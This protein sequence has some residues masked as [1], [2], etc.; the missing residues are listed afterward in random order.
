MTAGVS[1]VLDKSATIRRLEKEKHEAELKIQEMERMCA[2]LK[3]AQGLQHAKK[4]I[5][6]KGA[7]SKARGK[8]KGKKKDIELNDSSEE[9][10]EEE[11]NGKTDKDDDE[12]STYSFDKYAGKEGLKRLVEDAKEDLEEEP[13]K[14]L[15]QQDTN[16]SVVKPQ[17]K[18]SLCFF[19]DNST[20]KQTLIFA[21]KI[22]C[23]ND[24]TS[25]NHWHPE[26]NKG[27]FALGMRL[28]AV[29]CLGTCNKMMSASTRIGAVVTKP[30]EPIY[31]CLEALRGGNSRTCVACMCFSC[32][33]TVFTNSATS[34]RASRSRK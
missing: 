26:T 19:V 9:E 11:E 21:L 7:P 30:S 29:P 6:S 4:N 15:E 24:H 25:I 13:T 1:K 3:H 31:V 20:F 16:P 34:G 12:S 27:Y 23:M 8:G 32:F 17:A 33:Q 18:L 14:E 22:N 28:H 10:E 2:E 5:K